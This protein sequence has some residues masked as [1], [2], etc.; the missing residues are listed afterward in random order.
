MTLK[1]QYKN[2]M[3]IG[4]ASISNWCSLEVLD[5]FYGYGIDDYLVTCFNRGDGRTRI[6]RNKIY[7]TAS[8]R[9]YIRKDGRRFYLDE[10]MRIY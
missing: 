8:G 5:V 10:I 3:A 1:E 2:A 7:T 6:S 9:E 4:Y